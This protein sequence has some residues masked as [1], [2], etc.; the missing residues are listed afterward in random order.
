MKLK[1]Q[2]MDAQTVERALTRISYEIVE[3]TEDLTNLRLVGIHTRGVPMAEMIAKR[4]HTHSG[5]EVPTGVL[6]IALYRDDLTPVDG[7]EP[8]VKSVTLPFDIAGRDV[9]LVDDVL[10]TGRTVRAAIEALFTLGR[11]RTIRLAILIDR[12]HRELPIRADFVG[13]NMPTSRQEIVGVHFPTTDGE[14]GV[15]LFEGDL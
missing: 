11:P 12:G 7:E 3:R 5:V 10:Y 4:I 1:A 15:L 6:D 13:K 2:I 9:V 8:C 14:L